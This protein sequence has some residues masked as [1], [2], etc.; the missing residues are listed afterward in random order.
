MERYSIKLMEKSGKKIEILENYGT[1]EKINNFD[2]IAVVESPIIPLYSS[3]SFKIPDK[4]HFHNFKK[5]NDG[6]LIIII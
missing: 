1:I 3:D 4:L 6:T 2:V 5:G